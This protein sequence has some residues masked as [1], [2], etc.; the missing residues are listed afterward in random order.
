M[1]LFDEFVM[2]RINRDEATAQVRER[3]RM[4]VNQE[5][6]EA[7]AAGPSAA[8]PALVVTEP[9]AGTTIVGGVREPAPAHA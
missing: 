2:S 4:R 6:R 8:S 7:R 9:A 1:M 3:E 5:R